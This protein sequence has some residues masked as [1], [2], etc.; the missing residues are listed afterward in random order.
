[1]GKPAFLSLITSQISFG[2]AEAAERWAERMLE[3]GWG[4]HADVET[5]ETSRILKNFI[6]FSWFFDE[7]L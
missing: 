2:R 7:K 4:Q 6:E 5:L 1:M 3:Q